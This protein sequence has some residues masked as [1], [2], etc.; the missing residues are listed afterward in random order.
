MVSIIPI[1]VDET[2]LR[3]GLQHAV[4]DRLAYRLKHVQEMVNELSGGGVIGRKEWD[5]V[6]AYLDA[7]RSEMGPILDYVKAFDDQWPATD[8]G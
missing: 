5:Q 3:E 7:A 8:D 2:L 6:W 4:A 1:D